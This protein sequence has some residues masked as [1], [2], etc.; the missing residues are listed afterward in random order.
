MGLYVLINKTVFDDFHDDGVATEIFVVL[1]KTDDMVEFSVINQRI[2]QVHICRKFAV[3][4]VITDVSHRHHTVEHF[5]FVVYKTI[6]RKAIIV[7]PR[8]HSFDDIVN[9]FF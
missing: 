1:F 9:N 6:V 4:K 5:R 7:A 3:F 2:W 8:T